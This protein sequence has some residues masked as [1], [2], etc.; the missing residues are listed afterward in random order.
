MCFYDDSACSTHVTRPSGLFQGFPAPD[1]D[2]RYGEVSM[3]TAARVNFWAFAGLRKV[4]HELNY[5]HS[6]GTWRHSRRY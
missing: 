5:Q 1:G 3:T 4:V 2:S 6:T